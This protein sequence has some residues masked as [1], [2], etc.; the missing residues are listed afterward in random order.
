M[1]KVKILT[2]AA[3]AIAVFMTGCRAQ[4]EMEVVDIPEPEKPVEVKEE[5][6]TEAEIARIPVREERVSFDLAEEKERAAHEVNQF[7]VIVGSFRY[8]DNAQRFMRQL[9]DQ[10]FDPFILLSE[11][12]FHRVCVDSHTDETEAR[13]RVHQIRTRYSDYN[14]AW[15]LIKR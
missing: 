6:P 13:V 8:E 10:G 9:R 14:D 15:L 7:F 4:K 5:E 11:F 3:L 1:K 2:L 12:G